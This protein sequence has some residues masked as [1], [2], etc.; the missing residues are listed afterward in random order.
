MSKRSLVNL[1][2][3][4][5]FQMVDRRAAETQLASSS[6]GKFIIRPTTHGKDSEY[7]VSVKYKRPGDV[8]HFKLMFDSGGQT[9]AMWG[10][11]FRT[12]QEFVKAFQTKP[13]AKKGPEKIR[14]DTS[15]NIQVVLVEDDEENDT[16]FNVDQDETYEDAPEEDVSEDEDFDRED[17]HDNIIEGSIVICTDEF[18]P[19]E[20]GTI[21]MRRGDRLVVLYPPTE[22]WVYVRRGVGEEGYVPEEHVQCERR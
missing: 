6:P 13:I 1:R 11:N 15:A 21:Y 16:Y 17:N 4:D 8:H 7:S 3:P 22:G 19:E 5:W 18:V 20:E 14:L 9:W 12:L 10:Q 2:L